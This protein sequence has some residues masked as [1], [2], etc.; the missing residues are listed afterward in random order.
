MTTSNYLNDLKAQQTALAANLT[1][2][3]VPSSSNELLNT[4]VPKVLQIE[5]GGASSTRPADR[6]PVPTFAA[7]EQKIAI[8]YAIGQPPNDFAIE[9]ICTG[10]YQVDWGNNDFTQHASDTI[11]EYMYDFDS[12]EA[13]VNS[14]GQKYVWIT[15]TPIVGDITSINLNVRH[16]LRPTASSTNLFFPNAIE[17][18]LQVE[19]VGSMFFSAST[20][21]QYRLMD[22]FYWHGTN[23]MTSFS[24]FLYQCRSL[25]K[26][27]CYTGKGT[28]FSRFLASCYSF[29]EFLDIDTSKGETFVYFL[30]NCLSYNCQLNIDTSSGR[31]F[32]AFM[33][34]C[35]SY[36]HVVDIDVGESTVELGI[37][38][39]GTANNNLRGLRL[40][41]MGIISGRIVISNSSLTADA[42]ALL[43]SDLT[44]RTATTAGTIT[45]TGV[46]GADGLTPVQREIATN[47]N[48][49]IVG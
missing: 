17:M 1:A 5:G 19:Q 47:K 22:T 46:F 41:N 2:Q 8:L 21:T 25:Q 33:N 32:D 49:T 6:P 43:F 29:N 24:F 20:Y 12:I 28:N 42:L 36:S 7:G 11:A 35:P 9:L 3:G 39:I 48:W 4:L 26:F 37:N 45:I 34:P 18:H 40:R 13:P 27:K 44:D 30:N 16:S 23:N 31:T 15:I 10:G 38:F 14:C